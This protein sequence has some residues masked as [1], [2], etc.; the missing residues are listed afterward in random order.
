MALQINLT[1]VPIDDLDHALDFY[2]S[3]LG[4]VIKTEI[5]MGDTRYLTVV[6]PDNPDG[7]ELCLEPCGTQ[8]EVKAF[9]EWLFS[10]GVPFTAFEVDDCHAEHARLSEKG[11]EFKAEPMDDGTA[12]SA[13]LDDTCGN[14]IMIYQNTSG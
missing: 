1:S 7:T 11:V 13:T 9:K 5:P 2:T 8:P 10:K 14:L 4:F 3:K 12:I 6:S